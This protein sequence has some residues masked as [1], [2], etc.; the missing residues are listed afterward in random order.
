MNNLGV[1]LGKF[2]NS[3]NFVFGLSALPRDEDGNM[4][5]DIQN[6]PYVD[7][8]GYEMSNGEAIMLEDKY[9]FE[10]CTGEDIKKFMPDH[11]RAWYDQP[12]C[13]GDRDNVQIKNN[14]FLEEFAFPVIGIAYCKNTPENQNWCKTKDEI[15]E[16]L[17][18]HPAFFAH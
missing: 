13:F 8:I 1:T 18:L 11:A 17:Q 15:D 5:F 12:L 6:N 2:N 10:M 14:W 9:E 7:F 4:I 3:L 16:F